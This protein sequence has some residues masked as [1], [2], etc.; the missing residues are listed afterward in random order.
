MLFSLAQT[1]LQLPKLQFGQSVSSHPT[2]Y[3][4]MFISFIHESFRRLGREKAPV[5]PPDETVMAKWNCQ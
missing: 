3:L 4:D 2:D 1:W 5:S